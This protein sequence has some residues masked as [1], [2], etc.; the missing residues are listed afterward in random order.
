MNPPA[1]TDDE[2]ARLKAGLE[3]IGRTGA[4]SVGLRYHDEE[5][6]VVWIAVAGYAND[7]FETD[8][9]LHPIRA[10]LRLCE[11]LCDG[12]QCAHC[13]RPTGLDPDSLDT[14]PMGDVVC[15]YQY[16]PELKKFRRGCEGGI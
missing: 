9:A 4:K 14:M 16:D 7:R 12:G 15:W 3:F 8:A 11:R 13:G 2:K 1:F 5:E 6:P 10:V